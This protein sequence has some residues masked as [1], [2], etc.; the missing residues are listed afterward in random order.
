MLVYDQAHRLAGELKQSEEYQQLLQ[1]RER[2]ERVESARAMLLD[3][4]QQQ[5]DLQEALMRGETIPPERQEQMQKLMEIVAANP[6]VMEY[7]TAELRLLRLMGDLEK[8]I[9]DAAQEALLIN[10]NQINE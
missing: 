5:K 8:I 1:A 10:P 6:T 9:W 2:V 7:R 4:Q 3:F